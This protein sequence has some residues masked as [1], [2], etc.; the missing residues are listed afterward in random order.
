MVPI[1]TNYQTK[2]SARVSRGQK[3][4]IQFGKMKAKAQILSQ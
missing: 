3:M 2:K 4:K 1:N